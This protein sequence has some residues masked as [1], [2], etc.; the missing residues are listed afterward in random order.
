MKIFTKIVWSLT[1]ICATA[2]AICPAIASANSGAVDSNFNPQI[3]IDQAGAQ[4]AA[5][6]RVIEVQPD[7]KILVGGTFE[8]ANG[9][10]RSAIARFNS[11]GTLDASFNPPDIYA[12]SSGYGGN[13]RAI[14]VLP[15]NQ[16]L[17]GGDFVTVNDAARS[18]IARLNADGSF[19]ASFEIVGAANNG[20]LG[21]VFD[22][23]LAPDGK[24]IAAGQFR[25]EVPSSPNVSMHVDITR[26]NSD[27][28]FDNT[29]RTTGGVV[30]GAILDA[31]VL[32]DGKIFIGLAGGSLA[33][34][35]SDGTVDS[36]FA[37]R[38]FSGGIHE[39][40]VQ[41]NGQLLICGGFA[42][43]NGFQVGRIAR[44]NSDGSL[45]TSFN[46]NNFGA[47]N[48][49]YD[50]DVAPSGKIIVGGAFTTFN[51]VAR[52]RV[53]V[54]NADGTLDE[55]FNFTADSAIGVNA[56]AVLPNNQILIAGEFATTAGNFARLNPDGSLDYG[57][58]GTIEKNGVIN[59]ILVQPNG[60]ILVAGD[61][62]Y[63][64]RAFRF[65]LARLN[66]DGT[67]D[68]TFDA[69]VN[70]YIGAIALQP[71]GKFLVGGFFSSFNGENQAY[72]ARL[73]DDGSLDAGFSPAVNY[74]VQA[75]AV[76][77]NGQIVIGGQFT[78]VG[79]A[80]RNRFGRINADGTLDAAFNQGGG[81]NGFV[82]DIAVQTDGKILIGGDFSRV[83]GFSRLG[84]A[85]VNSIGQTR[86]DFDGDG[87]AD[88]SVWRPSNG[89]W[90]VSRSSD[91]AVSIDQFG[92]SEDLIAPADYDGDG[93]TDLAV[94]RPSTAVW[95]R[96][97]SSDN[98]FS[99]AQFGLP[100]DVPVPADFDGDGK[101][102]LA[103]WR[104]S[105][106][107]WY[108]Y[109]SRDNSFAATNWGANGDKPQ[110]GD[111]DG[112]GRQDFAVWRPSNAVWYILQSSNL[113]AKI[114][115]FGLTGDVPAA[116]DF[117]GDGKT[118]ISVFR[119]SD[120]IW[121]RLNSGDG[122]FVGYNFG[123]SADIPA[124]ADYDGDGLA[125]FSVFRP[126]SGA[127][128]LQRTT[129]GFG[130][131]FFGTNGDAPTPAAFGR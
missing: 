19:D 86:F 56:A 50:F 124:A 14:R 66:S 82:D 60:K 70:N 87:R 1:A 78:N 128:Y 61:F 106:A 2:G 113:T 114:V 108:R 121:Y 15:N 49:I 54:L 101:A 18:G 95:Y 104:P 68:S 96:I 34:L 69:F 127:W 24:I 88:V 30:S 89:A 115:Q 39:I 76:Q 58:E 65:R 64:N 83:N 20:I 100:G 7:G 21:T 103:V 5:V 91:N 36:T 77:A 6:G 43:L 47:N 122:R 28:G 99:A 29:Y 129:S 90:F 131:Q 84:L 17:I 37:R 79:G 116:A 67:V 71:D 117:D 75:L 35:N 118:D 9:T 51:N 63:V 52:A 45:D 74:T 57:F 44:L 130:G 25:L 73:S 120:N 22:I 85:R 23:E 102:D 72:L 98:S 33:R 53:A 16:I 81:A 27:G 42:Q 8:S 105:D 92:L 62:D 46:T 26:L 93:K 97:N 126:A 12:V 41:P 55:T 4:P 38:V 107:V 59:R 13:I 109:N 31:A 11:D 3:I 119:P 112:D 80:T 10:A 48:A 110:I 123:A 40:D 32:P 94:F 111:F 125:D